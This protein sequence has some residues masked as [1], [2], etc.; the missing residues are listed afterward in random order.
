MNNAD[1]RPSQ[2]KDD[3]RGLRSESSYYPVANK[4]ACKACEYKIEP[5]KEG[6]ETHMEDAWK[7][8][9]RKEEVENWINPDKVIELAI[10]RFE[11]G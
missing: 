9:Q 4:W 2:M 3:L 6:L 1:E 11:N 7:W 5:K 10:G 8:V